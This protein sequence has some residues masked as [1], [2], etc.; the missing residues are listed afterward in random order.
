LP[1]DG[2][3]RMVGDGAATLV[4]RAFSA[5][6]CHNR[7]QLLPFLTV[8]NARLLKFTRVSG[9]V[10]VLAALAADQACG[11]DQ[12]ADRSRARF[13]PAHLASC[14]RRTACWAATAHSRKPIRQV[15]TISPRPRA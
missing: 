10:D 1:E 12:Q 7:P 13:W 11:A 15:C 6:G 2:I 3:G 5:V 14:F 8:Y 9:I 4:A